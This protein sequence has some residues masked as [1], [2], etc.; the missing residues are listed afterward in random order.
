MRPHN[1]ALVPQKLIPQ[2][3]GTYGKAK[4]LNSL[5]NCIVVGSR[6]LQI[7]SKC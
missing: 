2:K 1:W 4:I 3:G 7:S 5:P 6:T